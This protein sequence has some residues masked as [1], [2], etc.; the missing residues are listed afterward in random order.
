MKLVFAGNGE[1]AFAQGSVAQAARRICAPWAN[2]C[3]TLPRCCDTEAYAWG[4]AMRLDGL[5]A[6]MRYMLLFSCRL[7]TL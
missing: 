7:Q 5:V 3:S 1:G 2:S 4:E 6:M